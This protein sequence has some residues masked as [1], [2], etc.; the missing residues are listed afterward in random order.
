MQE[1]SELAQTGVIRNIEKTNSSFIQEFIN[2]QS[3]NGNILI[4][5]D[6]KI[7]KI[8]DDEDET[9]D[10][11][12]Q[13]Y[14]NYLPQ[15]QKG[16]RDRCMTTNL[17]RNCP[18]QSRLLMQFNFPVSCKPKEVLVVPYIG[19]NTIMMSS[20]TDSQIVSWLGKPTGDQPTR[21]Y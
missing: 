5:N 4:V 8:Y 1:N 10:P 14:F 11:S 16:G 3:I 9:I 13:P 7:Y 15:K 21:V 17:L 6:R 12:I 2:S 20:L 18:K 19:S